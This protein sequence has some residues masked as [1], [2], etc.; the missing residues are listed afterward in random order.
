VDV[1]RAVIERDAPR[2][3]IR[4]SIVDSLIPRPASRLANVCRSLVR[5]HA[6]APET[7]A[8]PGATWGYV[9]ELVLALVLRHVFVVVS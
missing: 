6:H 8:T 3:P 9:R 4:V 5:V 7:V 1:D 2:C